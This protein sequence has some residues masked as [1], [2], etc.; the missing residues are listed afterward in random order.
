MIEAK[1]PASVFCAARS[2]YSS[3][4]RF[5]F[6]EGACGGD[7]VLRAQVDARNQQIL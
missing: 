5:G 1:T 7:A 6:L 2:V 3:E 4:K